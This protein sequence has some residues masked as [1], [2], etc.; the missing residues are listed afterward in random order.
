MDSP[1]QPPDD[2]ARALLAAA[3][4]ATA[5]APN[6][7]SLRHELENALEKACREMGV[8]WTPFRL[9]LTLHT[10]D[11]RRM[12]FAD[13]AHGAVIIEYEPP[14]SLLGSEKSIAHAKSQAE[15]YARLLCLEEGRPVSDYQMVIWDGSHIAFGEVRNG[16][17]TGPHWLASAWLEQNACCLF[18]PQWRSAGPSVIAGTYRRPAIAAGSKTNSQIIS[19]GSWCRIFPG[20]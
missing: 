14:R 15:E 5:S 4:E 19:G 3:T 18:W 13:V 16:G 17:R 7:A 10:S 11:P 6:E 9:D 20:N 2:I 12:R 8:P 1:T